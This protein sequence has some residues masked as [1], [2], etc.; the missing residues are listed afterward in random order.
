MTYLFVLYSSQGVYIFLE[1]ISCLD[2]NVNLNTI[3]QL[4]LNLKLNVKSINVYSV[5]THSM[6]CNVRVTP[7]ESKT[8]VQ[9]RRKSDFQR[10]SRFWIRQK[11][12]KVLHY[13]VIT[14]STPI[15][16]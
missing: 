14:S 10:T 11:L 13:I 15:F 8:L 4:S 12:L 3:H 16:Q 2:C 6:P 7:C 1:L 9:L 5:F